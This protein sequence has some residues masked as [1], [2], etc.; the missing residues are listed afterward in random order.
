MP[1]EDY[2]E[3]EQNNPGRERRNEGEQMNWFWNTFFARRAA[4]WTALSTVVMT[5][6][7]CLLWRVSDKANE[8]TVVAQRAFL[9]ISS[10]YPQKIIQNQK[11][12]GVNFFAAINNSGETPAK[13]GAEQFNYSVGQSLPQ[14][15]TDFEGLPHNEK[16]VFVLGPKAGMQLAPISISMEDLEAAEQGKKHIFF[17]GWTTYHD[18]FSGTPIR[19]SEFCVQLTSVSFT[20]PDHSLVTTDVNFV[21]PP[22]PIHNCYDEDCEDYPKRVQ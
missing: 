7:S 2:A 18:I 17:W 12:V 11:V 1:H 3:K 9:T 21:N 13:D 20:N 8:T 16:L 15:G 19:L 4:A 14:K 5:V 6:F 22:C 10:V